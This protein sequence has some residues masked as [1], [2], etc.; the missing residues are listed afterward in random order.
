MAEQ[1]GRRGNISNFRE[2]VAAGNRPED[3]VSTDRM[4]EAMQGAGARAG[5]DHEVSFELVT[6]E[7]AGRQCDKFRVERHRALHT[8]MIIEP[9]RQCRDVG[10]AL[11]T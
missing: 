1:G 10:P 9:M 7:V 11:G 8:W 5:G 2:M 3:G 6:S 4:G